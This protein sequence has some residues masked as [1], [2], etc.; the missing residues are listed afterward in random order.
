MRVAYDITSIDGQPSGVGNYTLHLLTHLLA[1]NSGHEYM[2]LSNRPTCPTPLSA[3]AAAPASR[4]FPSRMLWM[5]CVLPGA[6]RA[7]RPHL[8]HYTNSIGPLF[9]S[10]PYVVTIHDMT[11]SLL[12]GYHP[13]RKQLLV[14]P[15]VALV[16]RRARQIITVSEHARQDVIRVLRVPA[17][18]VSV[19]LEAAAPCFRPSPNDE[20]QRVRAAYRIAGPYVL[21]VGTLEPRKNLVRLV[22]A[23]NAL[24]RA[25][26]INQRLVI[27]GARG[28]QDGPIF[29]TVRALGCEDAIT[30]TGY[31]PQ[32]DLPALYSAADA[33]VF[34]SLSEGFGLPVVEAMACGTPVLISSA[35]ALV[36]VAGGAALQVNAASEPS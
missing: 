31:V 17:E 4:A 27:V 11:L 9:S 5:Q 30:F 10:C 20:Q 12:P 33:F 25:G 29:Q 21:Y 13:W 32:G 3:Y 34:P 7:L 15:I 1:A 18:R 36:E 26:K 24:R 2:P 23:W 35:P 6:L 22:R 8:C 16:A 28:W 19:T 14:R